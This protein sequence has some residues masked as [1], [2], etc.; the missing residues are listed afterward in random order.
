MVLLTSGEGEGGG[1]VRAEYVRHTFNME[2]EEE[3]EEK[4]EEKME[5]QAEG[6]GR[7]Q[8]RRG[9]KEEEIV[10]GRT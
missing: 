1:R 3:E 6:G 7:G 10:S 5:E 4:M 9:E 8:G 2:E